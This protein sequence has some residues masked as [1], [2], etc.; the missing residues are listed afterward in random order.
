MVQLVLVSLSHTLPEAAVQLQRF[1]PLTYRGSCGQLTTVNSWRPVVATAS[2]CLFLG[3]L[4]SL[5]VLS[6]TPKNV[7]MTRDCS[8]WRF[9]SH[10]FIFR[11]SKDISTVQG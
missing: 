1:H 3:L 6:P 9:L 10:F 4:L 2:M 11:I 5:A 8:N 7:A